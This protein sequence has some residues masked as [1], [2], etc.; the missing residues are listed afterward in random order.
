[1]SNRVASSRICFV[2]IALATGAAPACGDDGRD[3][4]SQTAAGSDAGSSGTGT[5]GSSK[6]GGAAGASESGSGGSTG[7]AASGGAA[8]RGTA[9]AGSASGA[10]GNATAPMMDD[11]SS[12]WSSIYQYVFWSCRN[13][14]CHGNGL[15]GVDFRTKDA[16]WASLIDQPANP[17]FACAALGK[18]RVKAGEPDESLLF[19]KLD[20]HSPCG[21]Q[22][23][24]GGE[25]SDPA[26]ARVRQWI[27]N[28]AKND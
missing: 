16:A 24:P 13:E 6:D 9:M 7:A 27:M 20:I 11:G 26:K 17:A 3:A 5:A 22:M 18:Q 2:A 23:P 19:L 21:Q 25:L 10:A 8:G 14:S 15:A 1:M 12:S 4:A 28:G